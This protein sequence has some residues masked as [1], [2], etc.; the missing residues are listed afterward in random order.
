MSSTISAAPSANAT[1]DRSTARSRRAAQRRAAARERAR[2]INAAERA[3]RA[4]A[5]AAARRQLAEADPISPMR[6]EALVPSSSTDDGVT[7]HQLFLAACALLALLFASGSFLS[8]ATR[9]WRGQLR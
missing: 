8:V 3:E 9:V 4:Q 7:S 5:H 1:S 6:L 2:R